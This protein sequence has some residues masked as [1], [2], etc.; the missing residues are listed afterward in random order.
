L[1]K[2]PGTNAESA[3]S[4]GSRARAL[5]ESRWLAFAVLYALHFIL[6]LALVDAANQ[7]QV[8]LKE[9][10]SAGY[11]GPVFL[12]FRLQHH[13]FA[14]NFY[15]YLIYGFGH[16][17]YTGLFGVRLTKI[18]VMALLPGGIYLYLRDRFN[19]RPIE[20]FFSSLAVVLL[21]G[22]LC[23]SWIATEMAEESAFGFL[24]LWLS[25]DDRPWAMFLSTC[26]AALA[27]GCYGSGLA[28]LL[29][30]AATQIIRLKMPGLRLPAI[31]S[32]CA[33]A[34]VLLVPL[35]W[36]TNAQTLFV[37]GGGVPHLS[38]TIGH[39]TALFGELFV[40]TDSYYMFA[41]GR[42]ALATPLIAA[43][44]LAGTVWTAMH[45]KQ[46]AW[47]LFALA[48]TSLTLL[49]VAGNVQGV[50]RAVPL[51]ICLGIFATLLLQSLLES[52][53]L[54]SRVAA[55]VLFALWL[56]PSAFQ[57]NAIRHELESAQIL[58]PHDFEFSVDAG[59]TMAATVAAFVDRS[60][61]LPSKLQG[62]EPDRT[63]SILFVLTQP[64]AIVSREELI[65]ACDQHGWSIPSQKPRLA[66][67]S[68]GR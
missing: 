11:V 20:A 62:Y 2:A 29:V 13:L 22:V 26:L 35:A 25:L 12:S 65:A 37:G 45:Y 28:F 40:R 18:T 6:L 67:L 55:L 14:T 61:P 43:L 36:W 58:L 33:A 23:L 51:M 59:S 39:L 21:P 38:G 17:F 32:L 4:T 30:V 64:S 16:H 3:L 8:L 31:L 7:Q 27:A 53:R 41:N 5:L 66:W 1:T 48:I 68:K 63:L 54:V 50:R 44:V 34:G 49:A 9:E 46:L 52:K 15:S 24:A 56:I 47:Q 42:A 60:R 57:Y 19:V 10:A